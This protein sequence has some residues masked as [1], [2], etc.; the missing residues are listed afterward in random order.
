MNKSYSFAYKLAGCTLSGL[1]ISTATMAASVDLRVVETTD[2]HSN[3]LDYDFYK[4][5]P[6][7]RF[8]LVRAASLVKQ[9]RAEV[10]NSVLVDNGDLIQG[11]PM[12]DWRAAEGLKKGEVHPTHKVMNSMNYDVGNIGNHEFNYGL[13]YLQNAI[14]GADFPYINANVHMAGTGK[15]LV[16]PYIIKDVSVKD[17]DGKMQT[18]QVGFIGFVPP[19][20]MQWDRKNL[21]GKV[22]VTDITATA[23]QLVPEMRAKGA[24]VVIAIPHSGLS[25]EPYKAMA[26]NSTYY[27]SQVSGIDAIMFGHSHSV[28]PGKEFADIPGV[29]LEKGTIN[30]VASVMPGRW[31]S[32]VGVV[33]LTLEGSGNDWKV[34]NGVSEARAIAKKDGTA[35]VEADAGLAKLVEEDRVA[36]SDFVN[37]PIGKSSDVM[38]SFLALVQD[39]PTV[40]IV[41]MA[42]KAYVEKFIQGDPDLADLPVL[43][44]AAPFKAGGRK[45]DPTNFTEVESG[46]LT[47]KNAA[48]LYLYPNTLVALKVTGVDVRE[49]LERSAGQ[50]KQIKL[51]TTEK[52][53]LL[54][55]DNFRTYNFD[56]I[57]GVSYE[58][59]ITQ[60]ARY[61]RKGN[62]VNADSHRIKNL[63]YKGQPIADDKQ[64][65][66]ATNNYRAFGGGHFPGA[67]QENIAFAAPDETRSILAN[68]ISETSKVNGEVKPTADNNWR[69]TPLDTDTQLNIVFET[70]S[71][72]KAAKF[73]EQ[74][75]QY[76]VKKVGTDVNGFA[77]YQITLTK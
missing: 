51:N 19:Q 75:S 77:L 53:D 43:A 5:K 35:L 76:P 24:D 71:S 34:V 63:T 8:G 52:Q 1:L 39:D 45:N 46:T 47:F 60:P 66:L 49:W 62:L 14:A 73:I 38:Y 6:T 64:F 59:D 55:W 17:K 48:D 23:R 56:V 31:G 67:G 70:A 28:F 58:I 54:D 36:T 41:N 50:F 18:I 20:I 7:T 16:Q 68:Y 22:T 12:G 11:S 44:A 61:D 26:E 69:F 74:R 29:D 40:Q 72:E 9:A 42:Q 65:L 33:D 2:I 27:L 25:S 37:R 10:T 15:P 32:H 3:V 30:G 13:E 57:E 4:G 21:D